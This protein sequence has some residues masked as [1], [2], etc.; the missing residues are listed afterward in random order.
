MALQNFANSVLIAPFEGANGATEFNNYAARGTRLSAVG[1]PAISTTFAGR[2]GASFDATVGAN[3]LAFAHGETIGTGDFYI[4][5]RVRTGTVN[6][7][8]QVIIVGAATYT[9]QVGLVAGKPTI[10]NTSVG[11]ILTGNTTLAS[12]TAYD[13]EFARVSGVGFIFVDGVLD[14]TAAMT[15]NLN[16][17]APSYMIGSVAGNYVFGGYIADL[18][19]VIG[20]GGHTSSYTVDPEALIYTISNAAASPIRDDL[21]ATAARIVQAVPRLQVP[22]MFAGASANDGTYALKVANIAEGY[23]VLV[24]DD[25]AGTAYD[26]A[27]IPNVGRAA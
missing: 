4:R 1:S 16:R 8:T 25:A 18:E 27:L 19:F 20:A 11:H 14:K 9:L 13:L 17:A 12:N 3:Y 26:D 2:S 10:T 24:L 15:T 7:S 22:R 23:N 21:N 5:V 6:A